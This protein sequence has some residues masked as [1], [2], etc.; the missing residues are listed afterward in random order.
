M[1]KK[2]YKYGEIEKF[3]KSNPNFP[4]YIL[5]ELDDNL[6]ENLTSKKVLIVLK[7]VEEEY[8]H[9]LITPGEA[10]GVVTAQSVGEPSTQMTLNTFHFA[11]VA[12]QSVEGLP[13][14]IEILDMKKKIKEPYMIIPLKKNVYEKKAKE[15]A[16]RIRR[17]PLLEF[18]KSVNID[19]TEKLVDITLDVKSLRSHFVE[20]SDIINKKLERKLR[21]KSSI[22]EKD[23]GVILRIKGTPLSSL[24]D[25][26]AT[27]EAAL[28]SVV[29]GIK[30]I[31]DV[32]IRKEGRGFLLRTRGIDI[33]EV[34]KVE[35]VDV[36]NIYCNS[37][38]DMFVHFGIEAAHQTIVNEITEL[39]E[40]QGLA[41]NQRHVLL[42]ADVMTYSGDL[43]GM[44][45]FGIVADKENTLTRASFETTLK[46]ISRAALMGIEDELTSITE[47]VMTNQIVSAGTG[48][49]KVA[50]KE[51][52]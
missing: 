37:I 14:L 29:L 50:V 4:S 24:K 23:Y 52:E 6:P 49:P 42:L 34:E 7:S 22:I 31:E 15:I 32:T 47:N 3:Q 17:T 10:I 43:R 1:A 18:S 25:L 45:R 27:K 30:K 20:I 16:S 48:L 11:G 40:K 28:N 19:N 38:Y 5:E 8:K 26:V 41:I 36:S 21:K 2:K 51:N 12:E 46:H 39:V 33:R 9:A 35:G 13:R 44:T